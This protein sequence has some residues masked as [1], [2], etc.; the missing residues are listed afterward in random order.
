M[1]FA[2]SLRPTDVSKIMACSCNPELHIW[3][4]NEH[5]KSKFFNVSL[6]KDFAFDEYLEVKGSINHTMVC[7]DL[8]GYEENNRGQLC[9]MHMGSATAPVST[10]V[11]TVEL[12]NSNSDIN[13]GALRIT[14]SD[15]LPSFTFNRTK[16]ASYARAMISTGY[17]VQSH[18]TPCVEFASRV[19]TPE[20]KTRVCPLPAQAYFFNM[21]KAVVPTQ[22]FFLDA[23]RKVMKR[24]NLSPAETTQII[25]EQ[26]GSES[27][28]V[29]PDF[30][31]VTAMTLEMCSYVVN[32][33]PY[34]QDYYVDPKSGDKIGFESFDHLFVR[35]A[36]D[37]EDSAL[38]TAQLYS[39]LQE[40][41]FSDATMQRLQ[42][43]AQQ[44]VPCAVLG[45]V[46]KTAYGY[47]NNVHQQAHMYSKIIPRT[48]F[49]EAA[50]YDVS[51]S[52]QTPWSG[53]LFSWAGEGTAPVSVTTS[54]DNLVELTSASD[55]EVVRAQQRFEMSNCT[56]SAPRSLK[57]IYNGNWALARDQFYS[58]D[59]HM[60][61]DYLRRHGVGK[62]CAFTVLSCD[63]HKGHSNKQYGATFQD[64]LNGNFELVAE[65]EISGDDEQ[66]IESILTFEHPPVKLDKCNVPLD[67]SKYAVFLHDLKE[68]KRANAVV[69]SDYLLQRPHEVKKSDWLEVVEFLESRKEIIEIVREGWDH[70]SR[71]IRF[72]VIDV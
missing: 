9:K 24:Y 28:S 41:R 68:S 12:I 18:Y 49:L 7:I 25:D 20:W 11:N 67:E 38:G 2:I 44:F 21:S 56:T 46:N 29:L 3:A 22:A 14:S 5:S 1:R 70:D 19:F 6:D 54:L 63:S 64:V 47:D 15:N 71:S 13:Y 65:G 10:D 69:Y 62:S 36:G 59:L 17:Q 4:V 40:M 66:L 60:Y 42:L 30:H 37:C 50:G 58:N 23:A 45:I 51:E 43:V 26:L 52:Q 55:K 34:I 48:K 32:C 16:L 31:R 57:R 8:Y 72:R 35:K 39:T 33:Y 53:A 61:T 27:G